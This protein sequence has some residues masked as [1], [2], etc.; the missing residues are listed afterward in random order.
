MIARLGGVPVL[1]HPYTMNND[2]LIPMFV[3]AGLKGIEIYHT[4]H[5]NLVTDKYRKVAEDF[6]L[7]TTGGSDCHGMGKGRVLMGSVTVPYE[8]VEQLKAAAHS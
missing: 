2:E 5:N 1:A 6:G 4:D 7:L 3:K 8:G